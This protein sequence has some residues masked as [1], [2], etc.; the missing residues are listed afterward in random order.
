[1]RVRTYPSA[2]PQP[3]DLTHG[4]FLQKQPPKSIAT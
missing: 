3:L 4:E 2:N 1:M